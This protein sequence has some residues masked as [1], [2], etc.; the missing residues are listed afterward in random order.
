MHE[1]MVLLALFREGQRQVARAER[2]GWQLADARD[3][4]RTASA[5]RWRLIGTPAA[6]SWVVDTPTHARGH[7]CHTRRDEGLG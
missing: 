4:K 6:A 5:K 3:S 2:Y 1:Q 7:H